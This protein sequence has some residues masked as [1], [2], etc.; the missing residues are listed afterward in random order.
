MKD[1]LGMDVCVEEKR[2]CADEPMDLEEYAALAQLLGKFSGKCGIG[3]K[4]KVSAVLAMVTEAAVREV[5]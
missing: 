1:F 3:D 2:I 5:K 4:L